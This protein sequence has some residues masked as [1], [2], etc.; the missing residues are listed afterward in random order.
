MYL[1]FGGVFV[2]NLTSGMVSENLVIRPSITVFGRLEH[3]PD[4]PLAQQIL[5]FGNT[6]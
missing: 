2:K 4:F 6:S 5:F 3:K 1:T